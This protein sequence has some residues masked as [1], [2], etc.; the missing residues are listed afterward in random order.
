M[1]ETVTFGWI[2]CGCAGNGVEMRV[3]EYA[4]INL[5]RFSFRWVQ[6]LW[7]EYGIMRCENFVEFF[8]TGLLLI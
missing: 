5:L 7:C 6:R 3:Q 4:F 2:L 1:V 8:T